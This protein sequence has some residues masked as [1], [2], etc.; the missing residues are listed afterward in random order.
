MRGRSTP[1]PVVLAVSYGVAAIPFSGALARLLRGV[2]LRRTGSGTVSGT[3]LYRVA[4]FGP[5]VVGGVLD[6]AK[7]S[8]GTL[9]A[10][11]DRPGLQALAAGAAVVGHNWSPLLGG[12]GGRGLSPSLGALLPAAPEGAAVLLVGLAVGKLAGA[13]SVGA[14]AADGVLVPLLSC[15]RGTRGTLLGAA[16]VCPMLTKRVLGNRLPRGPDWFRICISRLVFDQDEPAAP[17][18]WPQGSAAT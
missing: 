11:R 4:G 17:T 2:D 13:T 12:A 6:V 8:V 9:L 7:G 18:W 14:L 16:V 5:L 1:V 10:G 15:T 3:G